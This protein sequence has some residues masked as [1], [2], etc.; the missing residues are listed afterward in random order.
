MSHRKALLPQDNTHN[1]GERKS[2][3]QRYPFHEIP[4]ELEKNSAKGSTTYQ[5]KG[6]LILLSQDL[7]IAREPVEG[8]R[9]FR[10]SSAQ[11]ASS[12]CLSVSLR[13]ASLKTH[14]WYFPR[15]LQKHK[16][17]L[18]S[19][20]TSGPVHSD[21]LEQEERTPGQSERSSSS[22]LPWTGACAGDTGLVK[23]RV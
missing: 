21:L 17:R 19:K 9:R 8:S 7:W 22:V 15:R 6:G 10:L 16:A 4:G 2:N 1:T 12:S 11:Q 13:T 20:Q 5:Q 18:H 3:S 23:S 14:K